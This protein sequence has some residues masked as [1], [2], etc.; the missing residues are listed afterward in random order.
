MNVLGIIQA[1]M[2]STRLPGKVM[3]PILGKPMLARQLERTRRA[4][5]LDALMVATSVDSSDDPIEQLCASLGI[6]CFRGSLDDVLDR[7]Y[8]AARQYRP[9]HV[10]R[11]TADCPL[12][13]PEIVDR[14]VEFYLRGGF[15]H[16]GN[17]VEPRFPDGLD[18]EILRFPIL[19]Y[20][21]QHAT[22]LSDREHVTLF[23]HRQPDRFRIGSYRNDVDLS[24]LRWTVDEPRD[25][26]LVE[27]IYEALYP[28]NP[29]FTTADILDLLEKRPELLALNSGIDRNEGLARSLARDQENSST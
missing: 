26:V 5:S 4:R 13:D 25:F 15:D 8:Q 3:K 24:H 2:S 10:A 17:G 9:R 20:A 12:I 22:R 14:V 18:V 27:R 19:E 16:A 29:A 23:V 6:D 1:R 7:Y 28:K 11:M 21:W